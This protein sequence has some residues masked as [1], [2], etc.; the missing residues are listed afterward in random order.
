[1]TGCC[2]SQFLSAGVRDNS[3]AG[4]GVSAATGPTRNRRIDMKTRKIVANRLIAFTWG[5]WLGS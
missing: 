3:G 2:S 1:M 5:R 4:E